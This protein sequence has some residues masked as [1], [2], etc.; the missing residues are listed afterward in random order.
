MHINPEQK[1]TQQRL[2][3]SLAIK[4]S[5]ERLKTPLVSCTGRAREGVKLIPTLT[6][7]TSEVKGHDPG[8]AK[9]VTSFSCHVLPG[10][11]V[12]VKAPHDSFMLRRD[13]SLAGPTKLSSAPC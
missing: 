2:S 13:A 3:A 9:E 10:P 4:V 1:N 12:P 7:E 6:A 8:N 5:A 11:P